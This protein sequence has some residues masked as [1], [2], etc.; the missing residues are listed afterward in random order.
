MQKTPGVAHHCQAGSL[1][2]RTD[3]S[4]TSR[5]KIR[6]DRL[7]LA[8]ACCAA[9]EAAVLPPRFTLVKTEADRTASRYASPNFCTNPS[10]ASR[11]RPH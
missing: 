2:L 4:Q 7:L 9:H 6:G 3:K 10:C 11:Q 8:A 1:L 5:S